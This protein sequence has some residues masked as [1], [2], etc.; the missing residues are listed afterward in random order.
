MK[1]ISAASGLAPA[2]DMSQFT[3]IIAVIAAVVL[4]A[5]VCDKIG[6]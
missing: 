3:I 1:T 6:D 5:W 4:T 2:Q